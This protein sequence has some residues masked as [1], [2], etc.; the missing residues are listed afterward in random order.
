MKTPRTIS[1]SDI[2][3]RKSNFQVRPTIILKPKTAYNRK[4]FKRF[5]MED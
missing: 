5:N 2:K 3:V 1:Q 4:A